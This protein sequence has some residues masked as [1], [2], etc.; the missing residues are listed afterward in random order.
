MPVAP[1]KV[2]F[3]G[4][5]D[6]AAHHL[7]SLIDSQHQVCAVYT[8]P[9]RPAGRGRSLNASSVKQQALMS[10]LAIHQPESL[11]SAEEHHILAAFEADIMVVVAYGII[12][13]IEILKIPR[14]GCI[15]VHASLLP[16]WRG[17]AP[18]QRAIEAG[19]AETGVTIM[20]MDVGLD[21]GEMLLSRSI[22]ITGNDTSQS[23]HERLMHLGSKTLL[24]ALERIAEDNV[25][26]IEQDEIQAC[27]AKKLSK[28]EAG[29]DWAATAEKIHRKIRAFDPWPGSYVCL[30]GQKMKIEAERFASMDTQGCDPVSGIAV[31]INPGT[32]IS[33]DHQGLRVACAKGSLLIKSLQFAGKKMTPVAAILNAYRDQ[34]KV[35]QQFDL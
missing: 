9:D 26:R 3:A 28:S 24:E 13:P 31:A 19:D 2:V 1:L 8:Q 20:Q 32:I 6:F 22:R 18:I 16:R 27:Y 5:P 34:F 10:A 17:A 11:K 15:N 12:L 25:T 21:T 35:G 14:L 7:R 4:T 29:I 33:A 30:G 23:L